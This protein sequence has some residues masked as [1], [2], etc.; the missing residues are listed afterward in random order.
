MFLAGGGFLSRC[1]SE[2]AADALACSDLSSL[3]ASLCGWMYA[4]K[5]NS[6]LTPALASAASSCSRSTIITD[7]T[8]EHERVS[9]ISVQ[10]VNKL[11]CLS[12]CL[13]VYQSVSL[14][15]SIYLSI[16]PLTVMKDFRCEDERVSGAFPYRE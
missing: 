7:S 9:G 3:A 5:K 13:F 6:S 8:R 2:C 11:V 12:V 16:F 15:L 14:H 10:G 1:V 4:L